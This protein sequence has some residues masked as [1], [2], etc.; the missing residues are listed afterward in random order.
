MHSARVFAWSL[1]A[2]LTATAA[3][4]AQTPAVPTVPAGP[5]TPVA[6]GITTPAMPAAQGS[7]GKSCCNIWSFI[8]PTPDQ[9]AACQAKFCS[10]PF[11]QVFSAVLQPVSLYTGG[12]VSNNIC[13]QNNANAATNGAT[14]QPNFITPGD[15]AQPADSALGAASRIQQDDQEATRRRQAVEYLGTVDASRYPEAEAALISSLRGDRS[16]CVRLA[17]ARAL[18]RG[19]ACSKAVMEA[20]AIT[21]SGSSR[22]GFPVECSPR[23]KAAAAVALQ[24]CLHRCTVVPV[25]TE[26]PPE[27][28]RPEPPGQPDKKPTGA[29][30][31][32]YY[33]DQLPRQPMGQ[34]IREAQVVAASPAPVLPAAAPPAAS[35][36]PPL[37]P[38]P[39]V[40]PPAPPQAVPPQPAP[41]PV[42]TRPS[43][44]RHD[45]LGVFLQAARPGLAP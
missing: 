8:L 43:A 2:A 37:L 22:D 45:L 44:G 42:T 11:G 33:S 32:P 31:T 38:T 9:K 27:P 7:D 18:Q 26:T 3:L 4:S 16:E 40:L 20:L 1:T 36:E 19:C 25:E 15:L 10:S 35:P 41:A 29:L 12:L 14:G 28:V 5:T 21:I 17:A 13:P 34:V 23:V 39:A 6:P 24:G 30:L